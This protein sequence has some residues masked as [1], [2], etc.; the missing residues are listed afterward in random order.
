[1][2]SVNNDIISLISLPIELHNHIANHLNMDDLSSCMRVSKLWNQLF[3]SDIMWESIAR[4][5][6]IGKQEINP[7]HQ[8]IINSPILNWF[9]K[10]IGVLQ[11]DYKTLI[12]QKFLKEDTVIETKF[13]KVI[14]EAF[15]GSDAFRRYPLIELPLTS[16]IGMEFQEEHFSAPVI[17]AICTHSDLYRIGYILF[18]IRNNLTGKIHCEV[19]YLQEDYF[20]SFSPPLTKP[21]E[22]VLFDKTICR[23]SC[24]NSLNRL[25]R[26]IQR[27]PVGLIVDKINNQFIEGPSTTSDC[28]SVLELC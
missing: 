16:I 27:K 28:K 19:L 3:E 4:R 1:M 26:L 13:P 5:L 22:G 7:I 11:N 2:N 9:P 10:T 14:V 23:P 12:H 21:R 15:G 25:Q 17:R 18:R 8:I 20:F 6:H 24:D